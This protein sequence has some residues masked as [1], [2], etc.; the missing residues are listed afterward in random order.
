[1]FEV[2]CVVLSC[3]AHILIVLIVASSD[4][5]GWGHGAQLT[6]PSFSTVYTAM[7]IMGFISR[8]HVNRSIYL[9]YV[10]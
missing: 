1:M 2:L 4:L 5:L 8:T 7:D 9:L 3:A 6:R 10:W